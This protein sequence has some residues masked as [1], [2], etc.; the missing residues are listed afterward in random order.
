M[1]S[2]FK[3]GR[4]KGKRRAHWYVAYTDH[5]GRRRTQKAFTD[6]SLSEQLGAK[7]ENEAMLRQRGLIDPEDERIA[8][9][10]ATLLSVHLD[11]FD[12]SLA[13]NSEKY[14]KLVMSRVRLLIK[15]CGF[16]VAGDL[17]PDTVA[18]TLARMREKKKF[19]H[20]TFNHYIQA[21][22]TFCNWLVTSRRLPNNPIVGV[23]RLNTDVDV[24][25]QRR[26]L[27]PDEVAKLVESARKSDESIQC[28][29][30]E[31]RSRVYIT[32][33]M[34]GLRRKEMA[35]LTPRSFD[36]S[37]TPPTLTIQATVSKHRKKDVL[38]LH[39][40]L[41]AMIREWTTGLGPD[42][43]LFPELDRKRTWLMVKKD[44]ERAGIAYET[45]E[46][47]ADFHA[48]GRHSHVTE[49]LRSGASLPEARELAR[50]A[51]VRTTMKYTHIGMEDR[52]RALGNLRWQRIGSALR[53]FGGQSEA[54]IGSESG[55]QLDS[56]DDASAEYSDTS[57][58]DS[59]VLALIGSEASNDAEQVR[60]PPP[61]L[62]IVV[63]R[64]RQS[65]S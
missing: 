54:T 2:V 27:K 9:Q 58:N 22:H 63:A 64:R 11:A 36:L 23:E 29:S 33:Y 10:R 56:C 55:D 44:L 61:P 4:D 60:F 25:H 7:L 8:G 39:P 59:R 49:L 37:A 31:D 50:H 3:R 42:E 35:S 43:P 1:A 13:P 19:G 51:D 53:D 32:S 12:R 21:L 30:G 38:P 62:L 18:E 5:N 45:A 17:D 48:A 41:V 20:R 15:E 24:R 26:A 6:K 52:A 65:T 57:D 16:Q 28:Y 46:G 40:E 14:A 34:T 47:I